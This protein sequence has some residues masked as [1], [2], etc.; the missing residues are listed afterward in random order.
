MA[1][2]RR[3]PNGFFPARTEGLKDVDR[4]VGDLLQVRAE[5]QARRTDQVTLMLTVAAVEEL[6]P[7]LAV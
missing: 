5:K 6:I 4:N 3:R 2:C 7:S 1:L